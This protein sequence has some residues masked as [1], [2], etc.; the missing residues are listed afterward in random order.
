MVFTSRRSQS[1]GSP[2]GA[3]FRQWI[4]CQGSPAPLSLSRLLIIPPVPF[5]TDA[6]IF[7]VGRSE[8]APL[9]LSKATKLQD[10]VFRCKCSNVQQ[11]AAALHTVECKNV[12]EISLDLSHHVFLR[13]VD[14]EWLS[15]DWLLVQLCTSHSVRLKVMYESRKGWGN[16]REHMT[17]LL[18]ELMSRGIVDLVKYPYIERA[19][20]TGLIYS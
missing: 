19:F 20:P 12:R 18:P 17:R 15:L 13:T 4:W 9:D 7:D 3:F 6:L 10:I 1:R 5:P 2:R 14:E 11:I 8:M 16:Q